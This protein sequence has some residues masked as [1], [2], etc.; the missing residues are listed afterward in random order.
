MLDVHAAR[1]TDAMKLAAAEALAALV[2]EPTT[3]RILPGAFDPG[4]A[5][6][7]AD[8]VSTGATL[9]SAGLEIFGPVILEST[10]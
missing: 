8:V 4:V 2:T 10:A 1:C 6:A 9:A 3:T 5:D 7:V